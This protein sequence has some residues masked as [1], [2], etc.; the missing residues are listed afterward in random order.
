MVSLL[1]TTNIRAF[2]QEDEKVK[3]QTLED[4]QDENTVHYTRIYRI[5]NNYPDFKYKCT[6]DDGK[7]EGVTIE[8]IDDEMDRE[9]V[10]VLI[11]DFK[12]NKER[13]KNIPTRTGIYYSVDEEAEP[14]NGYEEFYRTLHTNI[15]YPKEAVN[16]PVEGTLYVKFVVGPKG[17][18]LY[19]RADEDIETIRERYL[20]QMK[21]SSENAIMETSGH[22]EPA[23]V[24]GKPVASW[25]IVPVV[26]D[27]KTHPMLPMR[28]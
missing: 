28:I 20:E 16:W 3:F 11:L 25:V 1:M 22:W 19:T 13:M 23:K 6:Y 10:R 21:E 14:E 7:V 26:F 12:K 24:D 18:I 2:S 17:E 15:D 27:A 4:L 9:K 5:V 8:G